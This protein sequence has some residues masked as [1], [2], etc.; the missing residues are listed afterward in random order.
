MLII[1]VVVSMDVVCDSILDDGLFMVIP[2]SI[3]TV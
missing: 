2:F 1:V 3:K